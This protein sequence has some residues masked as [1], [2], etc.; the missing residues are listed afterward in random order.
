MII[1][2]NETPKIAQV[3]NLRDSGRGMATARKNAAAATKIASNSRARAKVGNFELIN[4]AT[5]RDEKMS[6]IAKQRG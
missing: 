1:V 2:S 4:L 3:A 5:K 6:N